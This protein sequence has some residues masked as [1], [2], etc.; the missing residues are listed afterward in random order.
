MCTNPRLTVQRRPIAETAR[1]C[2]RAS[3]DPLRHFAASSRHSIP[4]VQRSA[5]GSGETES[6]IL[7]RR[8]LGT[9]TFVRLSQATQSIRVPLVPL[10]SHFPISRVAILRI[11]PPAASSRALAHVVVYAADLISR[12]PESFRSRVAQYPPSATVISNICPMR[13][14]ALTHARTHV[15]A[16]TRAT[17]ARVWY[18]TQEKVHRSRGK[19]DDRLRPSRKSRDPRVRIES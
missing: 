17:R 15:H 19:P 9:Q 10:I 11:S 16:R 6:V 3:D 12:R 2:A 13:L 4:Q 18:R 1:G 7:R 8:L 14:Y 5:D